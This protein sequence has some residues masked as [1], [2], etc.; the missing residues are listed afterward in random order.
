M[1]KFIAFLTAVMMTV[2]VC[3]SAQ[4][5]ENDLVKTVDSA[6]SWKNSKASP[7][8]NSGA[9]ASDLYIFALK[10]LG[11]EYD[12]ERYSDNLKSILGGYG[13]NRPAAVYARTILALEACGKDP[14][15]YENRDFVADGSYNKSNI[16]SA[17]DWSWA[18]IALDSG[19]YEVADW[20]A[21]T[22]E[23]MIKN[24]MAAQDERGCIGGDA[25]AT[26]LAIIALAEYTYD[27]TV[28]TY[29]NSLTGEQKDNT[30]WETVGPALNYLSGEQSDWGDFYDLRTTALALIAL[31]Y[32]DV[33]AEN[34]ERFIKEDKTVVDGLLAYAVGD[35][36]FSS[37]MNDSD[38]TATSYAICALTSHLRQLQGKSKL[39]DM[40]SN[41]RVDNV[42][43]S[44]ISD[45]SSGSSSSSSN[46]SSSSASKPSNSTSSSSSSASKP[47]NSTS[48][49]SSSA[50]KPSISSGS[51]SKKNS[52]SQSVQSNKRPAATTAPIHSSKPITTKAPVK[53]ALVGPVKMPGPMQQTPI[54]SE[55]GADVS[56]TEKLDISNEAKGTSKPVPI[57]ITMFVLAA[58]ITAGG[59]WYVIRTAKDV[60]L[61]KRRSVEEN[62]KA[63]VHR[64]TEIHGAYKE[65][66]K[67]KQRG[68]YKERGKYKGARRK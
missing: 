52:S 5:S 31:D 65:R 30:A 32:M 19:D 18:L 13:Q 47:S 9:E 6:V 16:R 7:Y 3:V 20:A 66:E 22:R 28:Y 68:K 53:K 61:P 44:I 37:D 63:R 39:F 57:T 4:Y 12:Y 36:S 27:D 46:S 67:Y 23:D 62:Y 48:S 1:K 2:T 50:S 58:L 8:Y 34:D 15:G 41:D 55:T 40:T 24:I 10:R 49:S 54:P 60:P 29:N 21:N 26:S 14:R 51:S 45:S 25:Y 42:N 59:V 11:V 64:R 35:G 56:E 43:H 17:E 38:S 33:D